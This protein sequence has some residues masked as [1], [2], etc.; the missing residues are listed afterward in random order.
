MEENPF[1]AHAARTRQ[2]VVTWVV[3]GLTI[4]IPFGIWR[5]L[6]TAERERREGWHARW[7]AAAEEK[8]R[9]RGEALRRALRGELVPRKDLGPCTEPL[10]DLPMKTVESPF[11]LDRSA[12]ASKTESPN[13]DEVSFTGWQKRIE[14]WGKELDFVTDDVRHSVF[15]NAGLPLPK[16]SFAGHMYL[17]DFKT[18][19]ILCAQDIPSPQPDAGPKTT[20]VADGGLEV[21]FT[22][23][24]TALW[25]V[26]PPIAPRD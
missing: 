4:L 16:D 18:N 17:Y 9:P 12:W 11:E 6:I 15:R 22:K 26:G 14:G 20:V 23:T 24:E 7:V 2:K 3:L 19:L 10:T 1:A 25:K 5:H 8:E 13:S 21:S